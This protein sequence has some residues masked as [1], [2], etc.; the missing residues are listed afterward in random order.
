VRQSR[1]LSSHPSFS[2][3]ASSADEIPHGHTFH[4]PAPQGDSPSRGLSAAAAL[5]RQRLRASVARPLG[6]GG[7]SLAG[8]AVSG[9]SAPPSCATQ[10]APPPI[11]A[12]LTHVTGGAAAPAPDS[13]REVP[14][15]A[16]APT[17][18]RPQSFKPLQR[19]CSVSCPCE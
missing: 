12:P 3:P 18:R 17:P 4:P 10:G 1:I 8:S 2:A 9:P 5:A 11:L 15:F 14:L 7:P 16:V 6:G 19:R 13:C